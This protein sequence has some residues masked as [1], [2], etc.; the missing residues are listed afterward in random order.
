MHIKN[1][2]TFSEFKSNHLTSTP[3]FTCICFL[4]KS[5]SILL[6]VSILSKTSLY[7]FRGPNSNRNKNDDDY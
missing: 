2:Y 3:D 6:T 5:I 7:A 4:N 1:Q